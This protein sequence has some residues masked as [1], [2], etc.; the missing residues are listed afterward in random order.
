MA[1]TGFNES[2]ASRAMTVDVGTGYEFTRSF[3]V[4][5]DLPTTPLLEIVN[6]IGIGLWAAHPEDVLSRAHKFDVKPRGSNFLLYEVTVHY[7]KPEEKNEERQEQKHGDPPKPEE[8]PAQMPKPMWSGGT[9]S[10]TVPFTEDA[11]GRK[12]M[13]SAGVPFPDAEKKVPTPTLT[14]TR[15]YSTYAAMQAHVNLI[16][17]K[18]NSALWANGEAGEWL[19]EGSKWSWKSE[20]QGNH[21]LRYI[22]CT[23]EFA[24]QEGGWAQK[25]LDVGYQQK[26]DNSGNPSE[27]GAK[28]GPIKGQDGKPVKEPVGLNGK[29]IAMNPPP[30][31]TSPPL[32][33]NSGKG[34]MPYESAAFATVVGTPK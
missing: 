34:A 33:I 2:I 19:C 12:V 15:A 18:V 32:I 25:L 11:D 7:K 5:V 23:Y 24:Y 29:G 21:A 22:E 8:Q 14:H 20:G 13:N 27:T 6:A 31:P 16:V 30:S 4:Q 1:V 28:L 17:G 26:V 9:T 10:A 3:T